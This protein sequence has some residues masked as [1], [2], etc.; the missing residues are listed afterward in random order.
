[1]CTS[2]KL[3]D[4]L[5]PPLF[6]AISAAR[7]RVWPCTM[8]RTWDGFAL[9]GLDSSPTAIPDQYMRWW[10]GKSGPH[11]V[12]GRTSARLREVND[13][14]R[15]VWFPKSTGQRLSRLNQCKG[16]LI[17]V[18]TTKWQPRAVV[19]VDYV[20]CCT[21]SRRDDIGC[22]LVHVESRIARKAVSAQRIDGEY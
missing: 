12:W 14:Q 10:R 17:S 8:Q 2:A 5:T 18:I 21:S 9:S 4:S 22:T 6:F 16:K 1:M 15:M 19:A 20:A 3:L 7:R 11:A 13:D